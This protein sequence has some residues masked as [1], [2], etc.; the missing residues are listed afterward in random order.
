MATEREQALAEL[1]AACEPNSLPKLE[2]SELEQIIDNAIRVKT[3]APNTFFKAGTIVYPSTRTGVKYR[4]IRAGTTGPTEPVWSSYSWI[5]TDGGVT[6]ENDGEEFPS[7]YDVNDAIRKAWLL[8]ASKASRFMK[9]G[10]MDMSQIQRNCLEMAKR[11][12]R[13][14]VG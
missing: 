13:P 9:T 11:F 10:G 3:W 7:I 2:Q 12:E 14:L 4:V 5:S 1:I 8:K 6:F